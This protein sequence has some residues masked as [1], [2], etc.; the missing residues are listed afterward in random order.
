[1]VEGFYCNLLLALTLLSNLRKNVL[2]KIDVVASPSY[3][4]MNALIARR[5]G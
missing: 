2:T 4:K 3:F 5:S 1:M